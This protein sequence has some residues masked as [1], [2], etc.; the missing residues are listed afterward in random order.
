MQ[1]VAKHAAIFFRRVLPVG[2]G[3]FRDIGRQHSL[4]Q[5]GLALELADQIKR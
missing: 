3:H 1:N 2:F 5:G 4:G